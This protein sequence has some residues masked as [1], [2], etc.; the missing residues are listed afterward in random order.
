MVKFDEYTCLCVSS[1]HYGLKQ[2]YFY[3]FL[4]FVIYKPKS[5][6]NINKILCVRKMKCD[7]IHQ[8]ENMG[9]NTNKMSTG[10][11]LGNF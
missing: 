11:Q 7:M 6:M 3:F 10:I 9:G 8:N 1:N 4:F 2:N 5:A